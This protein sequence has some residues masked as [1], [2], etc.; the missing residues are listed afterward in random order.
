[1]PIYEYYCRECAAKF[2]RLERRP[3]ATDTAVCPAG[4]AGATRTLS[5]FATLARGSDGEPAMGSGCGCGGACG[6]GGPSL[7]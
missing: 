7:N 2:E 1:M 4:H 6:C 3:A 5:L